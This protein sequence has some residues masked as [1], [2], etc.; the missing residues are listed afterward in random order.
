MFFFSSV[1]A[2]RTDFTSGTGTETGTGTSTGT[3]KR[4]NLR[5]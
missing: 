4:G 3:I 2:I 5:A 1:I